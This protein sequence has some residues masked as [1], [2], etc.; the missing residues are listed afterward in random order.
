MHQNWPPD[1]TRHTFRER[2]PVLE[3]E[4][5]NHGSLEREETVILPKLQAQLQYAYQHSPFYRNKWDAAGIAPEDIQSLADFEKFP[6]S[7]KTKFVKTSCKHPPFGSNLCI[8]RDEIASV[9]GTSGTTGKPTAFGIS[10]GDMDRI[11][12]AHAKNH[13]GLRHA[14]P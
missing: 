12:E 14:A 11:G 8:S 13:V 10:Q 9:H 2:C 6:L 7:P 5:G 3:P 4:T 1:T